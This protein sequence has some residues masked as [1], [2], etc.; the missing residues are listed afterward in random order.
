MSCWLVF[1]A[2]GANLELP[3]LA[4][5]VLAAHN[6]YR[7]KLGL[8]PLV[9]SDKLASAAQSWAD[10]LL[11]RREF[12]HEPQSTQGENLLEVNGGGSATP[13]DVVHDWA[14]ESLDYDY[15]SNR[16][17]S[18]CGHYTQ[19]VW[20]STAEVGCAMARDRH[21]EVWVCRYYPP[22][23]VVGRRPY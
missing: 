23:N 19:L 8:R 12:R 5:D 20:R 16:C 1:A 17:Y 3:P 7:T 22:G 21:R 14:S 11:K 13:D 6:A 10:K 18:K 2:S 9:W 4:S 15:A